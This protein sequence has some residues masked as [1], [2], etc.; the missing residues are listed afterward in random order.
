[1]AWRVCITFPF[2]RMIRYPMNRKSHAVFTVVG[3]I[4]VFAIACQTANPPPQSD[5]VFQLPT[6]LRPTC[7]EV[8]VRRG[9][10]TVSVPLAGSLQPNLSCTPL[11]DVPGQVWLSTWRPSH[12]RTGSLKHHH[13]AVLPFDGRRR[14]RFHR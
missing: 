8:T 2:L 13:V 5:L 1:M 3:L 10:I 9:N 11:S 6:C 4:G 7:E 12:N 14:H